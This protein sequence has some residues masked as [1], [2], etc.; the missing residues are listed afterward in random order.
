MEKDDE[1]IQSIKLLREKTKKI[2]RNK[3]IQKNNEF[4]SL[5]LSVA[6]REERE[7]KE[8]EK[9]KESN[10]KK[11]IKEKKRRERRGAKNFVFG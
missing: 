10:T 6:E 1:I 9:K 8:K 4:I 5:Q 3:K 11:E 2:N 7:E